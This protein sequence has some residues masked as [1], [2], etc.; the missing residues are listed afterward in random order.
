M[1]STASHIKADQGVELFYYLKITGIPFYFFGVINPS[2][3]SRFGAFAWTLPAGYTAARGMQLPDDSL[4]QTLADIVGGIASAE[5]I[6]LT[7]ADFVATS[8]FPNGYLSRLC[9]PGRLALAGPI[10][11][12]E[13]TILASAGAGGV[14]FVRGAAAGSTVG[15]S[16]FIHIGAEALNVN[17]GVADATGR[18]PMLIIARNLYPCCGSSY[19]ATPRHLVV[20]QDLQGVPG[21]NQLVTSE[22]MSL[23]GRSA[24]FFIG[25]I[26]PNG[27]PCLESETMTRLVGHIS[28][29]E[30]GTD[31]QYT[32]QLDSLMGDLATAQVAPELGQSQILPGQ[33]VI[34]QWFNTMRV[35]II[36]GDIATGSRR[37]SIGIVVNTGTYAIDDLVNVINFNLI[38]YYLV[39]TDIGGTTF[40]NCSIVIV[41]GNPTVQFNLGSLNTSY[42][43]AIDNYSVTTGQAAR[44]GLLSALGFNDDSEHV[45]DTAGSGGVTAG[46]NV[47]ITAEN[48]TPTVFI[49]MLLDAVTAAPSFTILDANQVFFSDQGDLGG[50]AWIRF[51]DGQVAKLTSQAGAVLTTS[52]AATTAFT[53]VT[54]KVGVTYFNGYST[55][56]YRVAIGDTPTVEQIIL[57]NTPTTYTPILGIGIGRVLAS[58]GQQSTTDFDAYPAGVGFGWGALV[59]QISFSRVTFADVQRQMQIDAATTFAD[60]FTAMA[61]EYGLFLVWNPEI[62]KVQ[63]LRMT[64]PSAAAAVTPILSDSNRTIVSDR[65]TSTIDRTNLRSSWALNWGWSGRDQKF[66][67]PLLTLA[68]NFVR[69]AFGAGSKNEKV[70]DKTL[71]YPGNSVGGTSGINI[72]AHILERSYLYRQPWA[73]CKRS[74]SKAGLVMTPGTCHQV[75]DATVINPFT[76]AQG[77]VGADRIF[78]IV[79]GVSMNPATGVGTVSYLINKYDPSSNFRPISPCALVDVGAALNGYNN[80]TGTVTL[81][82]H[83]ASDGVSFDGIDFLAGD[84]VILR[85]RDTLNYNQATTISAVAGDGHTVTV[86]AGLGAVPTTEEV[87]M[88]LTDYTHA[89]ATRK[90]AV[91]YQANEDGMV[92]SLISASRWS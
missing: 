43:L 57:W 45:S 65:T 42:R 67:G 10:P 55:P 63:L 90:S 8:S 71:A 21:Q 29:V 39:H 23:V 77:V 92:E 47:Q 86:A 11:E 46:G 24:A 4:E 85:T 1:A 5:R 50:A 52:Q 40:V 58:T 36:S 69:S 87:I 48:P 68:D 89:T 15:G 76:G 25:H 64:A 9:S 61:K 6:S 66:T 3:A 28:S 33:I 19:P 22:P 26:E 75:I 59:D 53:A 35:R 38:G 70:D 88:C 12:L 84:V 78:A 62:G 74:M 37:S 82:S 73:K 83:Y 14:I 34:N 79:M 2:D 54:V 60:V 32:F 16:G 27:M 20:T 44:T 56:Y 80:A 81:K 41:N 91:A 13:A 30:Y 49:P 31:G 72:L 17:G 18:T 7:I 51:G